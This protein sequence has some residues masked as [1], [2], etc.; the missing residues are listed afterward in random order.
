M[1]TTLSEAFSAIRAGDP[2]GMLAIDDLISDINEITTTDSDAALA[3]VHLLKLE[4]PLKQCIYS[5]VLITLL[6]D[7]LKKTG[8]EK[9]TFQRASLLAN[10]SFIDFQVLLHAHNKPLTAQQKKLVC[11]H[12]LDSSSILKKAGV[13]DEN[14]LQ[15]IAQH[16]ERS[17]GKGYPNQL[18]GDDIQLGAIAV[19]TCEFYMAMIDKR[20]YRN[21]Y[22]AGKA[23]QELY[24]T[25]PAREKKVQTH[26]IKILGIYPPG[27]YV[28]L[29]SGEIGLVFR[30]VPG[31][32]MPKV[33]AIFGPD[34]TPYL[35]SLLRDCN[36]PEY[37]VVGNN[38]ENLKTRLDINGLWTKR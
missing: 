7:R 15:I 22:Q 27:T 16:H 28:T 10:I 9:K 12:P 14:L 25:S 13:T 1:I 34:K 32:V 20:A 35:C 37:K 3:A 18:S 23:L 4:S 24:K 26:L 33:K 11:R 17:D 30:G 38:E 31:K 8:D 2:N 5:T 29:A 21:T 36:D 6:A 19:A